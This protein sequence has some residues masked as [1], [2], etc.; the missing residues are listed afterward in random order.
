MAARALRLD[1]PRF[2]EEFPY[3]DVFLLHDL[4]YQLPGTEPKPAIIGKSAGEG[5]ATPDVVGAVTAAGHG[6][7]GAGARPPKKQ[8][9]TTRW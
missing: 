3:F 4:F 2:G 1:L 9:A 7:V 5:G 6:V 8:T